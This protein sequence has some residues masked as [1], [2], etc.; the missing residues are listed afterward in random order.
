M[1]KLWVWKNNINQTC[2]QR[3]GFPQCPTLSFASAHLSTPFPAQFEEEK[4]C[5]FFG[6]FLCLVSIKFLCCVKEVLWSNP[7]WKLCLRQLLAPSLQWDG[8][9]HQKGNGEKTQ[10]LR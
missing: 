6:W 5:I 9:E 8:G 7:T 10:G 4:I 2:L 1:V 3:A